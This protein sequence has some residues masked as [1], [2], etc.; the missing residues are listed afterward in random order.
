MVEDIVYL[1]P[2]PPPGGGGSVEHYYHFLFDL[3][4]PFHMLFQNTEKNIRFAIKDIGPFSNRLI[5]LYGDRIKIVSTGNW[6]NE[7]KLVGMDPHCVD[8]TTIDFTRFKREI[9]E[10]A[11]VR[12]VQKASY[13]LLIER[14]KPQSFYVTKAKIKGGG[15]QRRSIPNHGELIDIINKEI[16]SKYEFHNIQLEN[17]NFK[18]QLEYF[19][20]AICVIGQHGAGLGNFIWTK[21]G[22]SLLEISHHPSNNNF[23]KI[24]MIKKGRY[25]LF[26]TSSRHAKLN[27]KQFNIV[28]KK[29]LENIN[30]SASSF[31]FFAN[32]KTK[33]SKFL[34]I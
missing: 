17:M 19:D 18:K 20:K 4:L 1:N 3:L 11:G 29:T 32:Y 5:D 12:Q 30:P 24:C 2:V 15:T 34:R 14:L 6:D 8:L 9:F 21:E 26:K 7:M 22:A 16:G 28:F 25:E 27:L 33:I 10:L 13:I 31:S 23:K